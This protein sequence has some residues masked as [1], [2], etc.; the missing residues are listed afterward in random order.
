MKIVAGEQEPVVGV[1]L[2]LDPVGVEIAIVRVAVHIRSVEV[3]VVVAPK[4]KC[5]L[6]SMP[7]SFEFSQD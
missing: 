6:P 4:R 5:K 3:A 2:V 7:P 1:P